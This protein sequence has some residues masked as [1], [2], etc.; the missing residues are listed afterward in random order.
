MFLKLFSLLHQCKWKP[1]LFCYNATGSFIHY[2]LRTAKWYLESHQHIALWVLNIC[3]SCTHRLWS[4]MTMMQYFTHMFSLWCLFCECK[5]ILWTFVC[6]QP[7]DIHSLQSQAPIP[8][9][10]HGLATSYRHAKRWLL[11]RWQHSR[12]ERKPSHLMQTQVHRKSN[13]R[14]KSSANSPQ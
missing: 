6:L 3:E 8:I 12:G 10:W 4:L 11:A 2:G 9:V 1:L 7:L 5:T 13:W 14:V